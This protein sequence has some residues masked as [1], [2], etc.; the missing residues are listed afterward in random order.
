MNGSLISGRRNAGLLVG[1]YDMK[2][3]ELKFDQIS[4]FHFAKF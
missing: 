4:K 1:A 2:S 3:R